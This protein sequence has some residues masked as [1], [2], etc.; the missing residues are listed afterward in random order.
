MTI[1]PAYDIIQSIVGTPQNDIEHL[2]LFMAAVALSIMVFY[3]VLYLF[4][5]IANLINKGG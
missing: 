4:K 3:Y 2:I 5:L 1:T